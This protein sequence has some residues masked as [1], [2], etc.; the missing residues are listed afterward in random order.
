LD[1]DFRQA[2]SLWEDP[3]LIEVPAKTEDELRLLVVGKINGKHWSAV[4]TCRN[5]IMRIISERRSRKEEIEIY[6]S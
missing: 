6:E 2:Q 5:D 4:I 1:R 3:G